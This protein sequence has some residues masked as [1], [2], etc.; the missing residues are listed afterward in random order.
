MSYSCLINTAACLA[1]S[2]CV[3]VCLAGFRDV[4]QALRGTTQKSIIAPKHINA[5]GTNSCHNLRFL[6]DIFI[7]SHTDRS[8]SLLRKHFTLRV[9]IQYN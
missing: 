6:Q 3:C 8:E 1:V 4:G 7:N 2:V 5:G 9:F